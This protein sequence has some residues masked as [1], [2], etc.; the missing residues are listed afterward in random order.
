[1]VLLKVND[2]LPG[3]TVDVAPGTKLRITAEAYGQRDQEP[4][5][6]LEII[7]HGK[8]LKRVEGSN[9][10]RLSLDLELPVDHGIWI[11]A[12]CAAGRSHV[13]HTTPVYVTVNGGGFHN[14]AT[15]PHYLELSE[16]YLRELEQEIANPARNLDS[17][18]ARHKV[19]L[20]R[21]IAEARQVLRG[22]AERLK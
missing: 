6:S 2:H 17:Q 12:K 18:A 19:A 20:E 8:A 15:A 13:A 4:L 21:Q 10:G 11:A 3:D 9:A 1:V 5:S 22:L 16:Q 7:G 14:P